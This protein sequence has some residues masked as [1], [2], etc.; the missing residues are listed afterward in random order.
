MSTAEIKLDLFRKIDALDSKNLEK[1]YG[2]L[3]NFINSTLEVNEWDD[4]PQN[5]K[6]AILSGIR[7][8]DDGLGIDHDD[9]IKKYRKKF[10]NE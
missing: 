10:G 9:V 1:V 8:L 4:M 5:H 2:Y 7:E 3:L 6:D